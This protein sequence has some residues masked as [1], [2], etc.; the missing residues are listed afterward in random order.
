MIKH[1]NKLEFEGVRH[2]NK[3]KEL[4]LEL[5]IATSGNKE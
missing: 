1:R 2:V 5:M 4:E 3:M